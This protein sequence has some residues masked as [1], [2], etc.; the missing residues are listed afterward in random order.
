[1]HRCWVFDCLSLPVGRHRGSEGWL[2]VDTRDAGHDHVLGDAVTWVRQLG[3]DR[4]SSDW[5]VTPQS[6]CLGLPV[7]VGL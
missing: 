5:D 7:E 3:E 4:E 2:P 1:M 6:Q